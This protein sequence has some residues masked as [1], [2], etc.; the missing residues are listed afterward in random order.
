MDKSPK[1]TITR[2]DDEIRVIETIDD[3][4]VQEDEGRT[5]FSRISSVI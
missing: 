4:E 3:T 2:V 1:T 5:S